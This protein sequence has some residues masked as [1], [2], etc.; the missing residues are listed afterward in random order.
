MDD[1]RDRHPGYKL[2]ALEE[3]RLMDQR[4]MMRLGTWVFVALMIV[5]IAEY[6]IGVGINRGAWPFLAVLVVP[7]AGLIIVYFMHI[8]QLWRREE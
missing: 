3:N 7:G 1:E 2:F 8:S 4:R 6:L 5:E